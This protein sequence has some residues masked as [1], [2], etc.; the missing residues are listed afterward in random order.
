MQYN[1]LVENKVVQRNF[2]LLLCKK[3]KEDT[4]SLFGRREMNEI[5]INEKK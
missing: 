4:N 1:I 5:E 3:R 2:I